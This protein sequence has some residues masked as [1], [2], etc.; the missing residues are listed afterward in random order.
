LW[1]PALAALPEA[2]LLEVG[3]WGLRQ[4][5]YDDLELV[6]DWRGF[7]DAPQRWLRYLLDEQPDEPTS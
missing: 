1:S 5:A 6:R 3:E 2:T 4:A 7:L